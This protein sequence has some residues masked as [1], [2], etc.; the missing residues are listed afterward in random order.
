METSYVARFLLQEFG[1]F[2]RDVVAAPISGQSV[3]QTSGNVSKLAWGG[4]RT[5]VRMAR[6]YDIQIRHKPRYGLN[7]TRGR[8]LFIPTPG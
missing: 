8:L 6:A 1:G 5:V 4:S 3:E 7:N 2:T